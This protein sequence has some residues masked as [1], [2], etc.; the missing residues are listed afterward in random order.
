MSVCLSVY[1]FLA[2]R[3]IF[4]ANVP[5]NQ[6]SLIHFLSLSIFRASE[7]WST[8]YLYKT[9]MLDSFTRQPVLFPTRHIQDAHIAEDTESPHCSLTSNPSSNRFFPNLFPALE[10]LRLCTSSWRH[11]RAVASL[12]TVPKY[13]SPEAL[14]EIKRE[15]CSVARRN[16]EN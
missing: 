2:I 15:Y 1:M 13:W 5:L 4:C 6:P 7:T 3:S 9:N 10:L 12:V 16:Y 8:M 14:K 11:C